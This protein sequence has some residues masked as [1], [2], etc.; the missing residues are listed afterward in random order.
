MTRKGVGVGC[1]KL[2]DETVGA[3]RKLIA[4][5]VDGANSR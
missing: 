1:R 3:S 2:E 5:K 4:S